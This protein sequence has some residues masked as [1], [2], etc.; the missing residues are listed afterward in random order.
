MS[1]MIVKCTQFTMVK[2]KQICTCRL[3]LC[4]TF[5]IF[6]ITGSKTTYGE[7]LQRSVNLAVGLRK[8]GVTKGDV[9]ALSCENRFE[10]TI[11]AIAVMFA[12]G[13]NATLNIMYTKG[14]SLFRTLFFFYWRTDRF[15]YYPPSYH[16][17][18]FSWQY[19]FYAGLLFSTFL[20]FLFLKDPGSAPLF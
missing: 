20:Q 16:I 18:L 1:G 12:G 14:E 4:G 15:N 9:I 13:V 8:L 10:F 11:C 2:V 7:I 6:S 19:E 17:R 5:Q 3:I